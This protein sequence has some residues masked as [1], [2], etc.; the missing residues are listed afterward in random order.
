MKKVEK[1]NPL[2]IHPTLIEAVQKS[3]AEVFINNRKTDK[4]LAE[5]LRSN[6]KWGSRDRAFIAE[7]TYEIV[8][9][10]RLM[11]FIA[12]VDGRHISASKIS[13]VVGSYL[14]LQ[15][16]E[17]S[18]FPDWKGLRYD[19]L[20]Q[21]YQ[22]AQEQRKVFHSVPDWL[23]ALGE[24]ELG[25]EK[26]ELE[27][28]AMNKQAP[29][30]IRTNTLKNT[31]Q[32]L[33]QNLEKENVETSTVPGV[34]QALYLKK[35]QN[36]FLTKAFK[37]GRFEVQDAGSQLIGKFLDVAPGMRVIDACAGAGGKSLHLANLMENKGQIIAMDIEEWK[38]DELK[39]RAKRDGIHNIE[40][41]VIAGKTI[42]RLKHSADRL[43]L[44][45]PCS[46]LGTLRRNPDAK[47]KLQ[48]EFITEIKKVQEDILHRYTEMLKPGGKVVY[49]T[50]SILPSESEDQ[51]QKFLEHHPNYK[52]IAERRTSPAIEGF[53]G[54]YMALMEKT[55]VSESV[56]E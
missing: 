34:E 50:C 4:V 19:L 31:R 2:K 22:A 17:V 23:D 41:R 10:W 37:D 20:K 45:V 6:K 40:T 9:Y 35:R 30:C 56:I 21:K 52:L 3:L 25:I 28:A 48:E 54:F 29:V 1:S 7:T 27:L 51:V 24:T 26:W 8:R 12:E 14:V 47:W 5:V 53:D 55:A 33:I 49:A 36:I 18:N 16:A 42:K 15:N 43:L 39:K 13:K 11:L 38:L 32:E 46:G 44:D